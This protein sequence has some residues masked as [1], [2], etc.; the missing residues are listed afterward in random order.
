MGNVSIMHG[1][2]QVQIFACQYPH[3]LKRRVGTRMI[4]IGRL[5]VGRQG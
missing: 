1:L 2:D 5:P 3:L 4:R